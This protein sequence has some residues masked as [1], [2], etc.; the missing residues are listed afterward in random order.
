M[1]DLKVTGKKANILLRTMGKEQ[2]ISTH[3]VM[4]LEV[5]S[6]DENNFLK[7]PQVFSQAEIPVKKENIP[8]QSDVD[9]WPHLKEV[10][11][12]QVDRAIGL[13]IGTNV[14]KALEPWKVIH[15]ED[16]GPYAVKTIL[17]WTINGPLLRGEI[18]GKDDAD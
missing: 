15:S 3:V 14:Q 11:L 4:G 1:R 10:Q 16:G 8:Q 2:T 17:G 12:N 13:L 7:L 9:K 18:T 6:L 5:S